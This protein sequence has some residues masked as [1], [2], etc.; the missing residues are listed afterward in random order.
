M[1]SFVAG[2]TVRCVKN[3]SASEWYFERAAGERVMLVGTAPVEALAQLGGLEPLLG[4]DGRH[5]QP[6]HSS[7]ESTTACSA[8]TCVRATAAILER[9][10]ARCAA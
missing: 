5:G 10:F 4:T 7:R 2:K 3:V 9:T 8:A 1:E 6:H